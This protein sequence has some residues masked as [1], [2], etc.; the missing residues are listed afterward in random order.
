ME[1]KKC[2]RCGNFFVSDGDVCPNCITKD[3]FEFNQFKNYVEENGIDGNIDYL[4]NNTGIS[5]KN[6][7]RYMDYSGLKFKKL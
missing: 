6:I 2:S 4:A 5:G 3:K 1:F 7:S